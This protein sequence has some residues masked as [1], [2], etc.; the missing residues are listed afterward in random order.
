MQE[1]SC[2]VSIGY[3]LE[4]IRNIGIMAHIDAGKTTATER[5]LYLT[6][7]L[8]RMGEVHEGTAQMDW[9]EQ[10]RQRGVTIS[11]AA[12]TCYWNDAKI[13]IIDTPGHVDFT[14]EVERSLRV[15]DGVVAVFCAVGG[16]EAQ[17]ETVW[18]QA[19]RYGIPRMVFVNKMDRPGADF[20]A[21]VAEVRK[22]LGA[23]AV[24]LQ[25]PLGQEKDFHGVIDLVNMRMVEYSGEGLDVDI[26][27]H[28]V[29]DDLKGTADK[30]RHALIEVL[31]EKDDGILEKFI[32]G[33]EITAADLKKSIRAQ[34]L[35]GNVVPVL[36]GSALG[37]KGMKLLLDAIVDYLPSPMDVP[38][39]SGPHPVTEETEIR[40]ADENE[41]FAA[42]AFKVVTDPF[43]GRL[44]Y[45]RIYSG[46]IN[47]GDTILNAGTNNKHRVGQ[48]F[49]MHANKRQEKKVASAGDIIAAVGL[50]EVS[51]GDSLTDLKHPIMLEGIV[52]PE[53]VI[54]VAI[55]PKSKAAGEKLSLSMAKLSEEDP[56]FRVH[57]NPETGQTIISGMGEFHLEIIVERLLTEFEV[58]ANVGKPQVAYR[59]SIKKDVESETKFV[60]QTGGKGQYA[61]VKIRLE[62]LPKGSGFEFE[63]K[64][65]GGVVPREYIPAV[66]KGIKEAIQTGPL[67]GFP[68]VDLKAV[69]YDGS[70]HPVDSSEIAFKVAGSMAVRDGMLKASPVLLEPVMDVEILIPQE[71]LGDVVGDF[72]SRR[73]TLDHTGQKTNRVV[74][75]GFAPLSELFG[76]A[77]ALRSITQGRGSF[78][79]ELYGYEL[80]PSAISEKIIHLSNGGEKQKK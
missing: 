12:T 4:K 48:I 56:T 13:N 63:N 34:M 58:E 31:S 71:F 69:L 21:V 24:P 54:S 30:H 80:V 49:E 16:V 78:S 67:A 72:V 27:V 7:R 70:F 66:E 32:E 45:A 38:P 44:V 35:K 39:I 11:S 5:I 52:F 8:H 33:E 1:E 61:H 59:E 65:Q 28:D 10:E 62:P 40:K 36:C 74:V 17:S 25:F 64:I 14:A 79:M 53:P 37:N 6:G 75:K 50:R 18:H 77:T 26:N 22:R 29:P 55:E 20:A 73:G 47:Q 23:D 19:D 41:P 51:T 68:V 76:Y 60:K 15:L 43:A 42:L 9:M 3:P 46:V 2:E 57:I